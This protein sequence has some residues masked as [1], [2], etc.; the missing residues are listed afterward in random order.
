[1][2]P[3]SRPRRTAAI[4][5]RMRMRT[6]RLGTASALAFVVVASCGPM[7]SSTLDDAERQEDPEFASSH[8]HDPFGEESVMDLLAPDERDAVRRSGMTFDEPAHD[9]S[10]TATAAERPPQG[11]VAR[12]MDTA[13]KAT[14]TALGVGM[15]VGMAVAP[16]FLF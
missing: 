4:L 9:P 1:V 3:G 8:L 12:A 7:R 2:T 10:I 15:S 11:R 6:W 5:P 14:V 13:G 16:F